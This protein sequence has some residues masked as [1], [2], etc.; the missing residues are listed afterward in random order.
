MTT[1]H[2]DIDADGVALIRID[3]PDRP[4]NVFTPALTADLA[5]AVER[6][7]ATPAIKG[8][9]LTSAKPTFIAGADLK[10]LVRA[11]DD[12]ITL[13]QAAQRFA[14]ENALM[15]RMETGGKPF[16]AAINGLA[17]G[18][19]LELALACHYRVLSDDPKAAVGLPEVSVGLLPAG[20]GTQRLPRLI[21][22]EKALP[23]LTQ[24]TQLSGSA[25]LE[26]GIV[27]ALAPADRLVDRARD[28]VLAHPDAQQP[29][30]VKGFRVP[31]GAGCLAPFANKSFQAGTTL[32]RR[33][34]YGNLPAPLAILSAVFEG[35]QLPIDKALGVEAKY[36]A[37]LF[38]DPV[39]RNLMRTM[40]VNKGA[41]DRLVR[42]PAGIDKTRVARLGVLGAGMMGAGIAYAAAAAGIDVVLLD[43]TAEGAQK[44]KQYSASL[45]DRDVARARTT[46]D[47]ADVLLAR[48]RP[49]ADY[50]DLA[51]CELV[52]EAVFENRA[53][54]ADVTARAEAF[55][56]DDAVFA[57]NTSTLMITGLAECS[58]RP[59][60]FIGMHFFSP[61]ERMPLVEII[62][63][64]QTSE[65][66]LARALDLCG[67][68][69]KTPIVVNDGPSFYT[70]RVYCT[71]VDEGMQMLA[72]GVEPALIENAARMAGMPVGPLA[73]IDE[74]TI[75]L[76]WKVIQ[77]AEADGLDARYTRPP[78]YAVCKTM[79]EDIKRPGRRFGGG[80]YEYPEG[81]KKRLWPGLRDAFPPAREQ[82]SAEALKRR[83][84]AI[85]ALEAA[86]CM[87]EGVLV[88]AEDGDLGSVLGVGY[89]A[90]TGGAL[91]YID[92]V[93]I[94]AFVADCR[95]M[96]DA[97]GPRYLPG[98]WLEARAAQGARLVGSP[99]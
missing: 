91:S 88:H 96:A 68:L 16:A 81:G 74:T 58:R 24:G 64:A 11:F 26:L 3:L 72:E 13:A 60:N 10:D 28:W 32:A 4:V 63:G 62:L 21:G 37:R 51:G 75:D 71:Y 85:Q 89:P 57:S 94:G 84:L 41:A 70:T 34:G 78:G 30:D 82:P 49:T 27:D 77:Q 54:K 44:G 46:R 39:S 35:T 87:E 48:I 56:G 9:V 93:G 29:W 92:T 97:C 73:V 95:R 42:R 86:R 5:A 15:R 69:R 6:V 40:F 80:F 53:V 52:V 90:W 25:A 65:R 33:A 76:R 38:A 20:G 8:A 22:I 1:L 31:G 55:L 61:V 14:A 12:G 23:L 36:F 45:L 19:G 18:G 66:T 43:A 99:A 7:L 79:V 59:A 98:A 47:K 50:A 17:L 83:F 67:Q 2:F